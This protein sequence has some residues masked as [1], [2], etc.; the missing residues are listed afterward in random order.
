[1]HICSLLPTASTH[2]RPESEETFTN[3]LKM[4]NLPLTTSNLLDTDFD[5][6]YPV[7]YRSENGLLEFQ[8]NSASPAQQWTDSTMSVERMD[9]AFASRSSTISTY[10]DSSTYHIDN[11]VSLPLYIRGLIYILLIDGGSF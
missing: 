4:T 6:V 2:N 5:F 7:L 8:G 10:P 9:S 1:M 11:T 3:S